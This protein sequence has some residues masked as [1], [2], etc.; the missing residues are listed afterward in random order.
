MHSLLFRALRRLK[1][2]IVKPEGG[3]PLYTIARYL[4]AD[5]VI[6]EA[7]AHLGYDTLAMSRCWPRGH[8]HAF[9]PIPS[10]FSQLQQRTH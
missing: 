5:P 8:I 4:P 9:E 2:Y 1:S 10:I 7:G 3:I 6:V